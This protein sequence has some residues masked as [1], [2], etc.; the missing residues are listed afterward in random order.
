MSQCT[1]LSDLSNPNACNTSADFIPSGQ[2]SVTLLPPRSQ[3]PPTG[4]VS[5]PL[6]E[7]LFLSP[8]LE[9]TLLSYLR[10]SIKNKLVLTPTRYQRLLCEA[11]YHLENHAETTDALAKGATLLAQEE[12]LRRLLTVQ[13]T[14]LIEV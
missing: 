7:L 14:V 4:T 10:P 9:Q 8:S 2:S 1:S 11:R 6:Q 5:A 13:R 12:N 3:F